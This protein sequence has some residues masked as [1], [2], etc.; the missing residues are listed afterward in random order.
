[1]T[2]KSVAAALRASLVAQQRSG[3]DLIRLFAAI[4]AA[5]AKALAA[6]RV[7]PS[8]AINSRL[9]ESEHAMF[10]FNIPQH[11]RGLTIVVE[12]AVYP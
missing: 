10:R 2:S 12:R 6:K 11:S 5:R 7:E 4:S 3:A 9:P 1:L 8:R